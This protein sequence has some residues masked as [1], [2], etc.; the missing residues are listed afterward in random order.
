[1]VFLSCNEVRLKQGAGFTKVIWQKVLWMGTA[2]F[3]PLKMLISLAV[4][5]RPEVSEKMCLD[6]L[7]LVLSD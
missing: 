7:D 6:Q 4:S 3:R 1:M 2:P 5:P